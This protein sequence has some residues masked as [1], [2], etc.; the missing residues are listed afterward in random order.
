MIKAHLKWKPL[1]VSMIT[2]ILSVPADALPLD[3][4]IAHHP[5]RYK[6]LTSHL[7]P[8]GLSPQKVS[9]AYGFNTVAAKGKGQV[10]AVVAAFDDPSIEADLAVFN[11]Q[12][13]LPSCTTTNACF[14]KVYANGKKPR[15][16]ADWSGEIALDI[17]W[18]H[19]MAPEAKIIL[20]EAATNK[21]A[22]LYSAVRVA[23][24][25]GATVVSMSWYSDELAQQ[26]ELNVIFNNPK[27]TFVAAS[28]DDGAATNYP[29]S[30]PY[31]LGVG[32]STLTLDFYG[33]YQG[34]TAWSGSGGG[35][36][37]IESR[38]AYQRDLPTPQSKNKRGVPDVAYNA[39]PATGFSIYSSVETPMGKGWQVVG[40]T[41]AGT[42]QWAALV[43]LANSALKIRVG[44]KFN[45][46]LYAMAAPKQGNLNFYF[47]NI[48]AG[49]NG[50][51][52]YFCS[53]HQGYDYI[54]GLGSPQVANLIE[55]LHGLCMRAE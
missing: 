7:V 6:P 5:L 52:G 4:G 43:A 30:S 8:S 35:L 55:G 23:V 13:N 20:V 32:G 51:C 12:F 10:I 9:I 41:S 18:A 16:D 53:A 29:A 28:G 37:T 15:A 48:S 3:S 2:G 22:D 49:T 40:G 11:R 25:N 34:E 14:T 44:G 47:N 17:E 21:L 26:T 36:S 54:T 27:V 50:N 1:L 31:V 45:A 19:A 33:N 38:P 39:D 46:L 42:P 24:K